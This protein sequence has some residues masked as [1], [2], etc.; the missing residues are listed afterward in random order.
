MSDAYPE[1]LVPGAQYAQVV[2]QRNEAVTGNRRIDRTTE[3]LLAVLADTVQS[4][5]PGA[6]PIFGIQAHFE[7]AN[8]VKE[9]NIPVIREEGVEQSFSLGRVVRYGLADSL[10]TD[11]VLRDRSGI[12]IAVYDLKIG[13]AKLT[14][15]RAQ[16]IRNELR[17]PNVPVI[18][19]Q[20]RNESAVLR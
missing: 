10:R 6:G 1:P 2:P 11:V 4:L 20:Y 12:P 18:E 15:S 13:N 19:L 17:L 5:G 16:E 8:R 3:R 7:F 14:P 9:L